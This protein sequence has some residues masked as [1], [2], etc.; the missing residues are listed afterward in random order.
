MGIAVRIAASIA[1]CRGRQ[2]ESPPH[3]NLKGVICKMVSGM[4]ADYNLANNM[5][6]VHQMRQ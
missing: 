1:G 4:E 2:K 6:V 3:L 5:K